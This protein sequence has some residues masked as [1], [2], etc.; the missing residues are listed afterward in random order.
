MDLRTSIDKNRKIYCEL[1][2][3][4]TDT[5]NVTFDQNVKN[6]ISAEFEFLAAS[7]PDW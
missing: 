4:P 3:K 1:Y 2:Q 7:L 6:A 5:S